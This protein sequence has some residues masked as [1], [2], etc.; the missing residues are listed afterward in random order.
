MKLSQS[1]WKWIRWLLAGLFF[2]AVGWLLYSR[3]REMDWSEV[4]VS[5]RAYE[6]PTLATGLVFTLLAYLAFGCY[7]LLARRH[8]GHRVPTP[9]VLA[10][11]MVAYA[12]N[13]NLGALVGGWATR[14][15]LYSR[16]GV[17]ASTTTQ[18]IGLG[19]LSNWTGY[20]LIA[21]LVFAFAPPTLPDTWALS[22]AM[23]PLIGG[24][25][26]VTLSA[27]LLLCAF[28]PGRLWKI[29]RLELRAPT[30]AFAGTQL[31]ASSVH[32]LATCMV[33]SAF[34]PGELAFTTILGVLLMSSM[35]GAAMHIPAGLGVIEA[36]FVAVLGDRVPAAQLLGALLAYRATFYLAPLLLG[37]AVFPVLELRGRKPE[38]DDGA[39]P[40]LATGRLV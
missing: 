32:W 10:I 23:L 37:L 9:R 1:S 27:Y 2:G 13:L 21:G 17:T 8:V 33:I 31:A 7:D 40:G 28:R 16:V 36:V 38:T 34:L 29:R 18:I 14:F 5:V 12:L 22:S 39:S 24:G 35:A 15:R 20:V 3:G 4:W 19:I 6:L 25:L 30:L 11:A 26:L